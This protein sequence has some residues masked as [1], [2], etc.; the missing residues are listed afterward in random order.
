VY[1][2]DKKSYMIYDTLENISRKFNVEQD[3][4]I[5]ISNNKLYKLKIP[6][7]AIPYVVPFEAGDKYTKGTIVALD[8]NQA[9]T[10]KYLVN[11]INDI[12][13]RHKLEKE[14]MEK[15]ITAIQNMLSE[16]T[17]TVYKEKEEEEKEEKEEEDKELYGGKKLSSRRRLSTTSKSATSRRRRSSKKRATKRKQKR[18][19]RRASRRAY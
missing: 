18:R 11:I 14:K 10:K 7:S 3:K 5:S 9:S 4:I 15:L 1:D 19:Q 17:S 8:P 2:A 13:E 12:F 6:S 16:I